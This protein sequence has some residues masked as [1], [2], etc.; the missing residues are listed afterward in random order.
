MAATLLS[1]LPAAVR[2]LTARENPIAKGTH[3]EDEALRNFPYTC[4]ASDD[5]SLSIA[6]PPG[7]LRCSAAALAFRHRTYVCYISNTNNY[8]R[9][10]KRDDVQ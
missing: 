8:Y 1:K 7:D 2:V 5:H 3:H 6:L 4:L 10:I 9:F